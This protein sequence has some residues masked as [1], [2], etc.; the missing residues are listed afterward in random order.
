MELKRCFES[1][2]GER[3][4][5]KKAELWLKNSYLRLT[6]GIKIRWRIKSRSAVY[7]KCSCDECIR[8]DFID[9]VKYVNALRSWNR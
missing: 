6:N 2:D 3:K 8:R 1:R 4:N 9:R 7:W 5:I